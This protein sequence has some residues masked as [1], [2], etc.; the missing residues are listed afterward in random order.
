MMRRAGMR[1]A[2]A[3]AA[4]LLSTVPVVFEPA[5]SSQPPSAAPAAVQPRASGL[6]LIAPAGEATGRI[7]FQWQPSDVA[8]SYRVRFIDGR[9]REIYTAELKETR[10][11]LPSSVLDQMETT[12][13]YSW[14]VDALDQDGNVIETTRAVSFLWTR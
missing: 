11:T 1:L 10:H 14:R 2:R 7:E 13:T 8:A 6:A 9:E 12:V 4:L 5:C 3:A